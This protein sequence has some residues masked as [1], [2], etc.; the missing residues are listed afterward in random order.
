M[1]ELELQELEWGRP[2]KNDG[3]GKAGTCAC[4]FPL[5]VT[6]PIEISTAFNVIFWVATWQVKK[7]SKKVI[8]LQWTISTASAACCMYR[9]WNFLY[10]PMLPSIV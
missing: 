9:K 4:K 8:K 6:R 5:T 1:Q 10:L 2:I 3:S 7:M